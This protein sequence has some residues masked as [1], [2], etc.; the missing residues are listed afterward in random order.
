MTSAEILSELA[1][2]KEVKE[3][4]LNIAMKDR[5]RANDLFQDLFIE[6][7]KLPK[8]KIRE[9]HRKKYLPKL[10]T[11]IL[12]SLNMKYSRNVTQQLPEIT[13]DIQEYD[14]SKDHQLEYLKQ[15]LNQDITQE[16]YYRITILRRWVNGE[17]MRHIS[18]TTRIRVHEIMRVI[19]AE[20]D[21]LKKC[22]K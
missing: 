9:A 13:D 10:C 2:N 7:Y 14:L 15:Y 17:S 19:N 11:K 8:S 3:V 21:E 20:L 1:K 6:L 5:D 12:Y 18:R 4:A 22:L 16:N